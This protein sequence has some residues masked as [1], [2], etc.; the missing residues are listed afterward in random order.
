MSARQVSESLWQVHAGVFPSNCYLL[1][2]AD[3]EALVIDPGLDPDT[4]IA[5][6]ERLGLRPVGVVCTHGHFD[7]MGSA[8]VFQK[9]FGGEVHMHA[10]DL[11]TAKAANFLLM[12]FKIP[13]KVAQPVFTLLR[14]ERGA[15]R[16]G[17]FEVSH[18]L[19]PGHSPGSCFITVGD[20]C[21]TGDSLYATS[22]G[23]SKV[24]GEQPD[25]LRRSLLE[26]LDEINSDTLICPGHGRTAKM[27]DVRL[28]NR[29]LAKFLARGEAEI[30]T[31]PAHEW[32]EGEDHLPP[33][34]LEVAS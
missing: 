24:P 5:E 16:S 20:V 6:V 11:K 14:G 15:W 26:V 8:S 2:N 30:M 33:R 9:R 3:R 29:A 4:I 23:L 7:H 32:E 10:G 22:V 21:F 34:A 1:A 17:G 25:I 19:V 27:G 12:A 31:K 13:A 18:R 28:K